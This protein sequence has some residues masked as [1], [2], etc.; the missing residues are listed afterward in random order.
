MTKENGGKAD[1]LNYGIKEAKNNFIVSL[2]GDT[3]IHKDALCE[4]NKTLQDKNV[5]AVGGNVLTIQCITDFSNKIK[6]K[7]SNHLLHDI[8]FLEYLKGFMVY[9]TSLSKFNALAIISGAFGVFKRDVLM[10]LGGFA[11]TV[12]EDIE[13]TLKFHKYAAR[14]HKKILYN[15]RAIVFTEVPSRVGD[16]FRQRNRWQ[17]AFIDA[18]FKHRGFI[19]KSVFKRAVAFFMLVE[20]FILSI[21][22]MYSTIYGIIIIGIYRDISLEVISLFTIGIVLLFVYNIIAYNKT[23][24]IG[25]DLSNVSKFKLALL[26][27]FEFFIY[28]FFLIFIFIYGTIKHIFSRNKY[29]WN[30]MERSGKDYNDLVA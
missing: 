18:M 15:E 28:K 27:I 12:G 5:I 19:C 21:I 30:K 22:A 1:T 26:I 6:A 29:Q 8:Q 14:K 13:I 24:K 3:L 16:L 9:K 11:H 2:D 25:I 7:L 17:A 4:I 23:K 20:A 10:K